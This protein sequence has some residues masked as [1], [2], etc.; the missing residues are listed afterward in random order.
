[1]RKQNTKTQRHKERPLKRIFIAAFL[2]VFVSLCFVFSQQTLKIDVNLVNV[3]ATVKDEHG[4]FVTNLNRDDF[5]VYDDGQPQDIQIFEK[6]DQVDSSIGI[7][8]D[9]SGSMVDILPFMKRAIRDFTRTLPKPDEFFVVSFGT[10]VRLIHKSSQP[11]KHLDDSMASMRAYGTSVL[12]DALLYSLE[13]VE[14]SDRPRKALIVFTDGNDNGSTVSYGRVVDEAQTSSVLLY[15][16]AI[17]S[18]VLLDTNTLESLSDTS[19][20]RTLYVSK[21]ENI[22]PVLDQ[23]RIELAQ[24][25]Y[26]GY[27]VPRRSGVHRIRVEVPGR[28]VKVR[29]KTGYTEG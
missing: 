11:L 14:T 2:C 23:V 16:V 7:L 28:N 10:N 12:Y 4:D 3:F 15:F 21:Q 5:R 26:L 9:T 29:A 6:Q 19:G 22:S 25:Y 27:Y 1:M 8:T 13:K 20:G 17:G 24:Q 18:R